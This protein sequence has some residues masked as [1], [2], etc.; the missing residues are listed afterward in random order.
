MADEEPTL[1]AEP[2][3][4]WSNAAADAGISSR[5]PLP[6]PLDLTVPGW[7]NSGP[8]ATGATAGTPGTWTPAGA[9]TPVNLAAM[10]GK[11]ATPATAWTTGQYMVLG[12]G[13]F[14]HWTSTAWV[15][16]KA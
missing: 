1:L 15:A 6:V 7:S 11:T 3:P 8:P 10:T 14:A 12:D 5:E 13:T 4:G 16:G 2:T 9:E